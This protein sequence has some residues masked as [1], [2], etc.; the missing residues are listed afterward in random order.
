[1]PAT[2]YINQD[3]K[4]FT[5]DIANHVP[6]MFRILVIIWGIQVAVA[7]ILITRPKNALINKNVE[8]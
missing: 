6:S 4:Y 8:P 2:I 5:P 3:L 1:M 7:S